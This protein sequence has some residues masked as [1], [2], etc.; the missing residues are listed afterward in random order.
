[1]FVVFKIHSLTLQ[2]S[3]DVFPA[4]LVE[5]AIAEISNLNDIKNA[6]TNEPTMFECQQPMD[7]QD[8]DLK[9]FLPLPMTLTFDFLTQNQYGSSSGQDQCIYAVLAPRSHGLSSY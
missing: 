5:E 6:E 9:P 8:I 3:F 4:L 7:C 1:L 2:R